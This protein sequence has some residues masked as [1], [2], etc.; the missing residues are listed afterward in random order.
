LTRSKRFD[1]ALAMPKGCD[2]SVFGRKP[3]E[4]N[5]A[6]ENLTLLISIGQFSG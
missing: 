1:V 2:T 5:Y 4:I 3:A 6:A